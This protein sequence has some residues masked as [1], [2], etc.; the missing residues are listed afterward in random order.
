MKS[1]IFIISLLIILVGCTQQSA[2][3]LSDNTSNQIIISGY[4]FTPSSITIDVGTSVTWVNQDSAPHTIIS[5]NSVFSSPVLNNGAS[6]SFTFNS[7]G[8]YNYHCSIHPT[9]QG[10]IIVE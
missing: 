8:I 10:V 1:L 4:E 9:M 2:Q 3:N 6:Y 5:D 7:A